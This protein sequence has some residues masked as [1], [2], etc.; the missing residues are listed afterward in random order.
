MRFVVGPDGVLTPDAAAKLPGRGVWVTASR[1]AIALAAKKGGFARGL[2]GPVQAPPGL[3]DQVEAALARRCLELTGLC[4]RAGALSLGQET[5]EAALRSGSGR[6]VL[7]ASDAALD[8]RNKMLKLAAAVGTPA[9]GCFTNTEL[10]VALG[11]DRVVHACVLQDGMA[12]RLAAE[13]RR[14]G[15]FRPI[16]PE[17][18]PH[19]ERFHA[20]FGALFGGERG[21]ATEGS[22][23]D[24]A[25]TASEE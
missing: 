20:L 10:G 9:A 15:G 23:P 1:E 22:E 11:R 25:E 14:L 24:V 18:W 16:I 7:E 19:P 2:K 17:G 12:L 6:L 3:A 21:L 13:I 4:R 5:V 8:G